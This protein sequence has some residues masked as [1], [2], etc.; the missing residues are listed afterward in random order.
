MNASCL[1]GLPAMHDTCMYHGFQQCIVIYLLVSLC[2]KKKLAS[3]LHFIHLQFCMHERTTSSSWSELRPPDLIWSDPITRRVASPC[4]AAS[5]VPSRTLARAAG[6]LSACMHHACRC[7]CKR[8]QRAASRKGFYQF[9]SPRA[10]RPPP[11]TRW[12]H[13]RTGL[14]GLR[15]RTHAHKLHVVLGIWAGLFGPAQARPKIRAQSTVSTR[16]EG[17]PGSGLK[18][19]SV[20]PPIRFV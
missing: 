10:R 5:F 20:R 6:R 9:H 12:Q 2:I 18:F 14:I 8:R 15:A 3:C 16:L 4:I 13:A 11:A 17:G 19:R 1:P 7:R